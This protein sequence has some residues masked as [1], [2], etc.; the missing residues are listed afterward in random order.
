MEKQLLQTLDYLQAFE[1]KL[2]KQPKMPG[3]KARRLRNSLLEEQVKE[4]REAAN[5]LD[6]ADTMSNTFYSLYEAA[7][8]YGLA[9]RLIMLFDELHSSKMS[10]MDMDGNPIYNDNGKMIASDTMRSANFRP[11]IE[12]NFNLYIESDT[13]KE[14][15]NIQQTATEKKIA[16]KISKHLNVFD[17]LLFAIANKIEDR[18]KKRIEIKFPQSESDSIIVS[19]YGESYAITNS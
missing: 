1:V 4:L 11:I 12:R 15:A 14:I 9:D 19:V 16:R 2:P 6:V 18:L 13:M 8:E 10:S 17:R 7:H 3:I 5:I